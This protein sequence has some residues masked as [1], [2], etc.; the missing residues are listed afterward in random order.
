MYDIIVLISPRI[1]D[2]VLQGIKNSKIYVE[3]EGIVTTSLSVRDGVICDI[4]FK[5]E[6]PYPQLKDGLILIPGFIDEHIH[7]A[8]G[9]DS[10]DLN[11]RSLETISEAVL[12]EGTT[13]FLFT[14]M[15]QPLDRILQS[16]EVIGDFIAKST[17]GATPLGVHL[18]GPF[19]SKKFAGAQNSDFIIDLDIEVL[20]KLV[21]APRSN[22][23]LL[24]MTYSKNH[25]DFVGELLRLGIVPSLGHSDC[26]ASEAFDGI[27]QG[28]RCGTHVFNAMSGIHHRDIGVA[29]ALVADDRVHCELICDLRHVS[30][31]AIKLLYKCKGKD[32][33]I[34][35]TDSMEAKYMPDGEY[36]LGDNKVLAKD[37]FATLLDGTLAGSTLKMNDAVKNLKDVLGISLED[38]IDTATINPARNLKADRHKGSIAVGKDADFTV[39]DNNLNV[40]ATVVG[41]EIRYTKGEIFNEFNCQGQSV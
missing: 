40:Y 10:M 14:T 28:I 4:G 25:K 24:T 1:S 7:G 29:G 34:L 8:G 27:E 11:S 17:F 36:R 26:T 19:I 5:S 23:K 38:A 20:E 33:L 21:T 3:G 2:M 18:E 9:A 15:T 6:N 35:I 22:V 12:K 30:A 13:S 41:G 39:I 32:N 31:D 16:L 37:G